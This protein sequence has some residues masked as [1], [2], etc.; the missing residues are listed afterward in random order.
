MKASKIENLETGFRLS[1]SGLPKIPVL[2][3]L[4]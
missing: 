3:S 1:I 2:T 4:I